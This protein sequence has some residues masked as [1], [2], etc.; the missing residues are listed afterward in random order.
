MEQN[1]LE[2]ILTIQC[3]K[4]RTFSAASTNWEIPKWQW[5]WFS[6]IWPQ[7]CAS[8]FHIHMRTCSWHS[9]VIV[10]LILILWDWESVPGNGSQQLT[11]NIQPQCNWCGCLAGSYSEDRPH[12]FML[13]FIKIPAECFCLSREGLKSVCGR[14]VN[15]LF[16]AN[17]HCL[18]LAT[19]KILGNSIAGIL[20]Y[21][22]TRLHMSHCPVPFNRNF[23]FS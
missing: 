8:A 6:S 23:K 16:G 2:L 14:A 18:R 4:H 22:D 21:S 11:A 17:L 15:P 5:N 10:L 7:P 13:L 9:I 20:E 12:F 19:W 3:H 1:Q